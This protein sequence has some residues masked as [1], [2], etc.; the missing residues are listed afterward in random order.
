MLLNRRLL[1]NEPWRPSPARAWRRQVTRWIGLCALM[2]VGPVT[3]QQADSALPS[4]A[5]LE[6]AGARIGEIRVM[7]KDIFDTSDPAEDY[8]LFRLA[9]KLHIQTREGVIR[10]AIL[11]QSG[12]PVSVRAIEETERLL[13]SNGY[14]YEVSL[15]PVAVRDGLV[16]IEVVTRDTWSLNVGA[17][18]S[19][20]GGAN[21]SNAE[22]SDENLFGTGARLA[23]K[24]SNTVDRSSSSIEYAN[25]RALGTRAAV[26]LR[27]A[28]SSDGK[29][30]A[31]SVVRPFY[32]LDTRWTAGVTAASGDRIDAVYSSGVIASQYR[33][34]Q[35]QTQVFGG[36]STGLVD[37]WVQRQT[38]GLSWNEVRYAAEPGLIAPTSLPGDDKQVG[39]YFRYDLIEDRFNREV[40]RNLVGRPEFFAVGL[41][42]SVQIIGVSKALGSSRDTV[43]YA[44]SVSKGFEPLPDHTLITRASLSGDLSSGGSQSLSA[45][46]QYY[47]PQSKRRLFYAAVVGDF[48]TQA[49][50]V[51][52]LV[53]GGDN[54]LRGYPLRYQSGAR[55][56]LFTVEQ[57]FYTDVYLW[58]LFRIGG[59]AFFDV[60]RA[61]GGTSANAVNP[62]W[63]SDVGFGLRIVS[64]RSA[65]SNVVHIDLALPLNRDPG[66]SRVQLLV[67]TKKSF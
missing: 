50:P 6:A 54:G 49:G 58:R 8:A 35:S 25:D 45:A 9:N 31:L 59:A 14:L 4:F 39:P 11:F 55:R 37:G 19:R 36:W 3:A 41:N 17:G 47:L 5:E 13:R 2:L 16:D 42:A 63:L 33:V 43:L 53:L 22:L 52:S 62:G 24:R 44:A 48:I 12:D 28:S 56:M 18:V 1:L 29:A 66:I 51:D 27:H 7:P 61:W 67:T 60:G 40:N 57:R 38:V 34:K 10:R 23:L 64:V 15:R 46:A 21:A 30:S 65:F 26:A 32:A 20:S